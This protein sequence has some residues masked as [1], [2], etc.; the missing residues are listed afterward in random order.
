[1][2]NLSISSV[3]EMARV[4]ACKGTQEVIAF[5]PNSQKDKEQFARR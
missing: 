3:K 2:I 5:L 4:I 1:M